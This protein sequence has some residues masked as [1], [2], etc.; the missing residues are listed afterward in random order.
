MCIRDSHSTK[1]SGLHQQKRAKWFQHWLVSTQLDVSFLAEDGV[2][3]QRYSGEAAT[4]L[5]SDPFR[6]Q[7]SQLS[8]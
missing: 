7:S 4:D 8:V 6:V 3:E 2:G 1:L 5:R